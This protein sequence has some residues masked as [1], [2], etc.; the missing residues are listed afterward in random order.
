M[1]NNYFFLSIFFFT[2]IFVQAQNIAEKVINGTIIA[3][4]S[5][6]EGVHILNL[7]NEKSTVSDRNGKFSIAAKEDDLL[8]FSAIHLEYARKSVLKSDFN[9]ATL[10]V[11]LTSKVTQLDEVV[12]TEYPR[13]NAQEL[14][15]IDYKP[16]EYTPAERRL[17]TAEKLKWYS[18]LLI[19]LGGMSIDGLI[20]EISGRTNQLKKELQIEVK[21]LRFKKLVDLYKDDYFIQT[22][23]I[24]AEYVG[25]FQYY[26]IHDEEAMGYMKADK[27]TA[28]EFR[29]A[30]LATEFLNFLAT[31][32]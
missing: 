20:N 25:G 12:I 2:A 22:L 6:V 32:E 17:R 13:I 1:S 23:K 14:G 15:I 16:K 27:K 8:V 11:K 18:P 31:D 5:S 9:S 7:V 24:P 21:E 28:L 3:D 30:A 4:S 10:T 19:P 26:V 29:L